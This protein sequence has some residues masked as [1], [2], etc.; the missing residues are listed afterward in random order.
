MH[1][2]LIAA[3]PAF[4]KNYT[5]PKLVNQVDLYEMMCYILGIPPNP[6]DGSLERVQHLL[7]DTE[8]L[9]DQDFT[10]VTCKYPRILYAA[11]TE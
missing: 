5:S 11:I 8:E 6:N 3:G 2:F 1:P 9:V 4:K 7:V 10:L